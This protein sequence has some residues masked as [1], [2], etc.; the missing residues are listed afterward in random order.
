[1]QIQA[2]TTNWTDM[3]PQSLREAM[4]VHRTN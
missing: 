1:G 2:T 4:E 3:R